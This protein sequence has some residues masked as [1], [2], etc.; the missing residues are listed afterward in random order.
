MTL[1]TETF[2][3]TG[4]TPDSSIGAVRPSSRRN[5]FTHRLSCYRIYIRNNRNIHAYV[6]PPAIYDLVQDLADPL[7]S[8]T[9]SV[10]FT[11]GGTHST[12]HDCL[13]RGTA[14]YVP[15]TGRF[16]PVNPMSVFVLF[17]TATLLPVG[18]GYLLRRFLRWLLLLSG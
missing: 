11:G 4:I 13:F 2:T 9:G 14:L 16:Q 5:S 1:S 6:G 12:R 18:I 15:E 3:A 17:T 7:P 8:A 10:L